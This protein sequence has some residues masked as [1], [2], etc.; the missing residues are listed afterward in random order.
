MTGINDEIRI[1]DDGERE[2]E[3]GGERR[4]EGERYR[5]RKRRRQTVITVR[6]N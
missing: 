1:Y 4:T 5:E 3:G 6:S 2:R